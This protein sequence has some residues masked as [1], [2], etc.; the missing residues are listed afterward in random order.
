MQISYNICMVK[1]GQSIWFE[2]NGRTETQRPQCSISQSAL[3]SDT[4]IDLLH[5]PKCTIP[6]A[7]KLVGIGETKM[8]AKI[9]SGELP[10]IQIDGKTQLLE[11][12]LK[13]YL[14]GHYG[15]IKEV[16]VQPKQKLPALPDYVMDSEFLT[17]KRK[18]N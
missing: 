4:P 14:Q 17:L 9:K 8:R 7:C 16:K 15:T 12:D 1:S 5:E 2:R 11:R 3:S 10:V 18:E 13:D 6:K